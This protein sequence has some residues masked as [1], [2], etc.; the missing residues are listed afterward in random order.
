MPEPWYSQDENEEGEISEWVLGWCSIMLSDRASLLAS[1]RV[2]ILWHIF[3]F[4]W[5]RSHVCGTIPCYRLILSSLA[6]KWIWSSGRM[7]M[8]G[9]NLR[10]LRK[11]ALVPFVYY[12]FNI[13]CPVRESK[14]PGWKA[15][16]GCYNWQVG[17]ASISLQYICCEFY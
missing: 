8:I 12:Q 3:V 4:L 7:I 13:D 6:D 5:W 1:N 17:T 16:L 9:G 2:H 11:S 15:T 10:F 14:S